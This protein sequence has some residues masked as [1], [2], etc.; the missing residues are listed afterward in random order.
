MLKNERSPV[1]GR[2][3]GGLLRR[4][5]TWSNAADGRVKLEIGRCG[6]TPEA[7]VFARRLWSVPTQS[8]GAS[9]AVIA[10]APCAPVAAI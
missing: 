3:R 4:M 9:V 2:S 6:L 10:A 7:D 8:R 5:S 1:R